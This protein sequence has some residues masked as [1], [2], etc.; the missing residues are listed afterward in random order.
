MLRYCGHGDWHLIQF[1]NWWERHPD[2]ATV[3]EVPS[4]LLRPEGCGKILVQD[5]GMIDTS[6][7]SIFNKVVFNVVVNDSN[8]LR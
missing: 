7:I 6:T 8:V 3:M 2:S 1:G 5:L 4:R